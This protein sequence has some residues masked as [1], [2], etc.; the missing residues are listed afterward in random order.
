MS[1]ID[2]STHRPLLPAEGQFPLPFIR[3]QGLLLARS[4]AG[5]TLLLTAGDIPEG[6]IR[7]AE[8]FIP[9]GARRLPLPPEELILWLG[10]QYPEGIPQEGPPSR[11]NC[12]LEN[13]EERAPAVNLLNG[14]LVEGIRSGASD[15]HIGEGRVRYRVDGLLRQG[16]T[17][18]PAKARPVLSRLKVLAGL[19][20]T[21][22]RRPQEGRLSADLHGRTWDFRLSVIPVVEGETVTLRLFNRREK[23]PTLDELRFHPDDKAILAGL[24]QSPSGLIIVTGPTGSGKTTTLN[25]LLSLSDPDTRKIVTLED[26]VEYIRE[27]ITQIP[28]REERGMDYSSLLRR[29]LRQ[30]PDILMVGEIRDRA[31]ARLSVRA[32][33]TGHLVLTTLHT[34]DT[35]TTTVR[36]ETLGIAPE[37]QAEVLLGVVAQRLLRCLNG[38]GRIPVTEILLPGQKKPQATLVDRGRELSARGLVSDDEVS[39]MLEAPC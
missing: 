37:L 14:I 9:P 19:N 8:P 20:L 2:L 29:V 39:R 27:G 17:L 34:R 30:D 6:I 31:T 5:E 36:M 25:A 16:I 1:G 24:C 26:P 4:P 10:R 12:R 35:L 15:I 21:E 38:T 3:R 18:P 13:T 22:T 33:L 23:P 32:A 11:E 7:R 28:V